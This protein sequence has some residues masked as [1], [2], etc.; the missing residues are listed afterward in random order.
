MNRF[1][2]FF[3]QNRIRIIVTILIVVFIILIIQAI[4][5]ILKQYDDDVVPTGPE[6]VDTS[7]PSE[8][9][10]SGE[11][12][13]EETTDTNLN[14]ISQFV[15]YCNNKQYEN[16]YN[17]LTQDCKDELFNTLDLFVSN[18]CNQIF[19]STMTYQLELWHAATNTYTYRITYFTNDLLATG[20]A[21]PTD[22]KEDYIT[23]ITSRDGDRLN[24]NNFIEK[25]EI[26][27][28]QVA[29]ETAITIA[30]NDRYIYRDYEIY[31]ITISNNTDK[32]ILISN[33]IDSNDIC[34]V[35][36]NEVEYNSILNEVPLVNLELEPGI[37]KTIE[38]RFN[39]MYN[40]YRTIDH[41]SFK[42]IILDKQAYEQDMENVATISINIDI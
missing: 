6:I 10:I 11:E 27:N 14:V 29:E 24:I 19:T 28:S 32:T 13:P 33:G 26:N 25:D 5:Y 4:N 36:T 7:R 41:M 31:N 39:K 34:L 38:I 9:V 17:L 21:N 23:I 42:N 8:S 16:A 12:L 35:D 37:S 15:E 3:N 18:Y 2:R 40:L 1:I 30:V 22:T 20:N